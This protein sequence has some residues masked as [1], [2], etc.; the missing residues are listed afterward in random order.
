MKLLWTT[1]AAGLFLALCTLH[2]ASGAAASPVARVTRNGSPPIPAIVFV[3]APVV[4]FGNLTQR[5]PQGSR[6]VR[7]SPADRTASLLTLTPG[8]FAAADPQVSFDGGR[9]LFSAERAKGDF[10]Q[11]WEVAADGSGLRQITHGAGDCLEPKYLPQNQIVYTF[12]SGS[13]GQRNEAVYVSRM[14]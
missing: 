9:I 12:A 5:F 7:T 3:E 2:G 8:F 6:L 10:W 14:D 13:G 11:V 1:L 4:R